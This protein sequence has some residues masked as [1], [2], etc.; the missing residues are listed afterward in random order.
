MYIHRLGNNVLYQKK[1]KKNSN[2]V[3]IRLIRIRK[4]TQIIINMPNYFFS[5]YLHSFK[6]ICEQQLSSFWR[7]EYK[8]I[9]AKQVRLESPL[10][11]FLSKDL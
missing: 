6:N 10:G 7:A 9:T 5:I 2:F 4:I 1:K 11:I 8:L 3:F